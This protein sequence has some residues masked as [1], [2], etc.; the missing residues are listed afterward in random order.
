VANWLNARKAESDE[1]EDLSVSPP[2]N[3]SPLQLLKHD[4][5]LL[6]TLTTK[7]HHH[8]ERARS[9]GKS[10]RKEFNAEWKGLQENVWTKISITNDYTRF[11]ENSDQFQKIRK[12][13][14]NFSE[15]LVRLLHSPFKTDDPDDVKEGGNIGKTSCQGGGSDRSLPSDRAAGAAAGGRRRRRHAVAAATAPATASHPPPPAGSA[16]PSPAAAGLRATD[17]SDEED[18]PL[19]HRPCDARAGDYV[20]IFW[21]SPQYLGWWKATVQEI[22]S[23]GKAIVIY[24]ATPENSGWDP[25]IKYRHNLAASKHFTNVGEKHHAWRLVVSRIDAGRTAASTRSLEVSCPHSW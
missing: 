9:D 3:A 10:R 4:S 13:I 2:E 17:D 18:V 14:E 5:D 22:T 7:A 23:K 24:E 11:S 1:E 6:Y 12:D 19:L 16:A 20:E 21:A 15:Q 25:T 8:Y